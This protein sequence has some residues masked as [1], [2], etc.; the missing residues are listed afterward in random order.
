ME[1]IKKWIAAR[2]F[3]ALFWLVMVAGAV[4]RLYDF[5]A[6]SLS[7]DELSALNRLRYDGFLELM[8]E[9][10]KPD[11]HP[12]FVQVFLYYYTSLAGVQPFVVRLPFVLAG[13]A[14]VYL[15]YRIGCQWFNQATGLYAAL[16]VAVLPY[17]VLY[18]QLARPYSFGLL[19]TLLAAW[20]W[21]RYFFEKKQNAGIIA[22]L[23]ISLAL[24]MYTMYFSFMMAGWL[25][26]AGLFFLNRDNYNGFLVAVLLAGLLF[27]PFTGYFLHH[28]SKGGVG[29]A[30]GWLDAPAWDWVFDY[31]FYA[32]GSS[33]VML[34]V[35]LGFGG[36]LM[37]WHPGRF[38][39]TDR[40]TLALALFFLPFLFGF[41]YSHLVNPVLQYSVLLF[42]FPFL[43]LFFFSFFD[44][45]RLNASTLLVV[46]GLAG[47]I[48]VSVSKAGEYRDAQFADFEGCVNKL[49][50]WK[51][52]YNSDG[53]EMSASVNHVYYV[54]YYFENRKLTAPGIHVLEG[55][56][57]LE[58]A[59]L[60]RQL[61]ES[62]A[63]YFAYV[64]LMPARPDIPDV[65]AGSYPVQ[66]E[67]VNFANQAEAYLFAR[68]T[69]L[70][71]M[72][73]SK[74]VKTYV[75]DFEQADEAFGVGQ[76]S[77][78]TLNSV[79]GRYSMRL[80][81]ENEWGPGIKTTTGEAGL[82]YPSKVKITAKVLADSTLTDSP[83]VLTIT[84]RFGKQY[85]WVSGKMEHFVV[86][87]EWSTVFLT[88]DLPHPSSINDE[89]KV[90][91]WN[92]DHRT[93]WID[94]F[95]IRF[96]KR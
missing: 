64:R 45:G 50:T 87:G 57:G 11:F 82:R 26:L 2:P 37:L 77:L 49:I 95:S 5:T 68:D 71:P 73:L 39:M 92:R 88:A 59:D 23:G 96:Y 33:A 30:E 67:Y 83:V 17:P 6:W 42:A 12:P 16:F 91:I 75:C 10:V 29:G 1:T 47:G 65:I 41:V 55:N 18:S 89:L 81:P 86:A 48:W 27:L 44:T 21:G 24:A 79:S 62:T 85:V 32:F 9:G 54:D 61:R 15:V 76:Q 19:F 46:A 58:L 28:L 56:N 22:G 60:A 40:R 66:L 51:Q 36:M 3:E 78:D 25:V 8:R 38:R 13:I 34:V 53:I 70:T 69:S 43:L 14:S 90:F 7:N 35:L 63:P 74:P 72:K 80:N 52:K 84:D 4:L 93:L 94:D 20:F 31:L